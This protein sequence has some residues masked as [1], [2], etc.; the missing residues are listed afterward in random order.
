[1]ENKT[2][3]TLLAALA[4]ESRL[5]IFRLLV[6]QGQDGLPAG[7]IAEQLG[8]APATLSF[9]LKELSHAG[10]VN[11]RQESRFVFYSVDFAAISSLIA[12]LTENCCAAAPCDA[13]T[14][15]CG[16]RCSPPGKEAT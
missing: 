9:H 1:M 7:K 15:D 14:D 10:L 16:I 11:S 6:T 2:A 13:S 3:T 4:Q 8:I 5:A 12:F